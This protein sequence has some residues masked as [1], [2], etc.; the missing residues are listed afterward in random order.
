MALGL[1][2]GYLWEAGCPPVVFEEDSFRG[3]RG[4]EGD[5]VGYIGSV[6]RKEEEEEVRRCQSR[7]STNGGR[8]NEI[9]GVDMNGDRKDEGRNAVRNVTEKK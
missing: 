1:I 7:W 3:G 2:F 6:W 4:K 8:R 9:G 5:M